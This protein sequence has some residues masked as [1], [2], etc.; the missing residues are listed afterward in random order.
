M[1]KLPELV[2]RANVSRGYKLRIYLKKKHKRAKVQY[3]FQSSPWILVVYAHKKI[4][5][6]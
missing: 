6:I 4:C 3:M 1:L 5:I 2:V